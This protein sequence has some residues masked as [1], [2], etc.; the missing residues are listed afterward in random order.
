MSFYLHKHDEDLLKN[1]ARLTDIGDER[2][3]AL[4]RRANLQ[5]EAREG[6]PYALLFG[7]TVAIEQIL[8]S[9]VGDKLT[10]EIQASKSP[11]TVVGQKPQSIRPLITQWPCFETNNIE[12]HGLIILNSERITDAS[13]EALASLGTIEL[14]ILTSRLSQP[15]NQEERKLC[16][17]LSG[18]LEQIRV[19]IVGHFREEVSAEEVGELANYARTQAQ[20]AGF[21]STRFDSLLL[22]FSDNKQKGLPCEAHS[23]ADLINT[24][25]IRNNRDATLISSLAFLLDSIE[26]RLADAPKKMG[27]P[28][29]EEDISRIINQFDGHIEGFGKQL[30]KLVEAGDISTSEQLE[31]FFI[32]RIQ[33]WVNGN[34]LQASSLSLAE[35]FRPGIKAK[36]VSA[37]HLIASNLM[38]E[39]P[40]KSPKETLILKDE[41]VRAAFLFLASYQ[42]S[43]VATAV[44]FGGITIFIGSIFMPL[45]STG[46]TANLGAV[47]LGL[48]V[49]LSVYF[50]L[51]SLLTTNKKYLSSKHTIEKSKSLLKGW[52]I[53]RENLIAV[54]V[55]HMRDESGNSAKNNLTELRNRLIK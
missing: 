11:V 41:G 52:P 30:Q 9:L 54:F 38:I 43:R 1:L 14:G 40:S 4:Q 15:L 25:S 24:D 28:A 37:A 51:I 45:F 32:A 33:E 16:S 29:A 19:V 48:L 10:R 53:A 3:T 26:E 36:L 21:T 17:M 42:W 44:G 39:L 22:W 47:G 5:P 2:I 23:S 50:I 12:Y 18:I 13:I 7:D 31:I 35:K 55:E 6:S 34:S 20:Q 46:W 27:L 49:G 8:L